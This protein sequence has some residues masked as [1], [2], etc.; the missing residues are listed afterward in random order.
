MTLT[1]A[2]AN[3]VLTLGYHR[4]ST[5]KSD[6]EQVRY[7]KIFYFWIIYIMDTAFAI[8]FGRM[9]VV[10]DCEI[11]V[12]YLGRG[13]TMPDNAVDILHYVSTDSSF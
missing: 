9:S 8:R 5:M 3:I 7:A 4:S 6:N 1:T 12:P 10:R 13:F 11:D 2:A